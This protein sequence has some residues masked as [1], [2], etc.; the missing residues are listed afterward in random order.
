MDAVAEHL[1]LFLGVSKFFAIENPEAPANKKFAA[2][3]IL[4]P[5]KNLKRTFDVVC[6]PSNHASLQDQIPN[7]T[8]L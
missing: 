5:I 7:Q 2:T 8:L 1:H 3:T 6:A 4:R